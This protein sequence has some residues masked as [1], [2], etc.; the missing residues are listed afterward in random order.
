MNI[1][2]VKIYKREIEAFNSLKKNKHIIVDKIIESNI[3]YF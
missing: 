1:N 2:K 3:Y